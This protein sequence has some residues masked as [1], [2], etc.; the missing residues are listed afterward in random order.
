MQARGEW[1]AAVASCCNALALEPQQF[2]A[3]YLLGCLHY[4]RSLEYD[5]DL[6][7]VGQQFYL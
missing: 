2:E 3:C 6:A 1:D 4:E 7:Q 5:N